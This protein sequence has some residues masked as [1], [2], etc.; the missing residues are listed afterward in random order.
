MMYGWI[1]GIILLIVLI[2]VLVRG[3]LFQKKAGSD[4][5]GTKDSSPME[6]LKN[7][8][9]KGEIDKN[10]FEDRKAELEKG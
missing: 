7:R 10:E 9:A 1:I 8:Y 6:T 4:A 3:N 2:V 5:G